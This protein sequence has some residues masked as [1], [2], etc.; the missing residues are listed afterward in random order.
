MVNLNKSST[1]CGWELL[2]QRFQLRQGL[3]PVLRGGERPRR[4]AHDE[5]GRQQLADPQLRGR[6]QSNQPL[7]GPLAQQIESCATVVSGG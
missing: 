1:A 5:P 3:L 2:H 4:L 6:H 7:H